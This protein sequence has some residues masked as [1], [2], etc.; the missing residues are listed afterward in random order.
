VDLESTVI[1]SP[2]GYRRTGTTPDGLPGQSWQARYASLGADGLGLR[3]IVDGLNEKGLAVGLFYFPGS[4][5]YLPYTPAD[6]PNTVAPWELGS[7]ILDQFASVEEVKASIGRVV[8]PAVLLKAWNLELEVHY[9]VHDA[10]GQS[11]VIEYVDNQLRIHDNPLGV[12]TNSPSFDWHITNL[13][14]Y[15]NF[16]TTSHQP[17]QLGSVR[18]APLGQGSGMMG[19]PGDFTPPSRFVRA[20]A[21][22]QSIFPA[23]SGREAILNAFHILNNFDIPRGAARDAH[24]DAEG[25]VLADHTIWT[26]ASDLQARQ[27]HFRTYANSQIRRVDLMAHDLDGDAIFTVAMT[28]DEQIAPLTALAA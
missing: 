16:S 27:F 24:R 4:A 9:I 14:N 7:W 23:Q 11:L 15:V 12:F 13:R 5:G 1:L 3:M 8:V 17:L 10:S 2:R 18:L 20:V 19:M 22:S 26:A 25:N 6:A 28:G 21:F